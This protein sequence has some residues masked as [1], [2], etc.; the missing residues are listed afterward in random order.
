MPCSWHYW[1]ST[2][3]TNNLNVIAIAACTSSCKKSGF[4]FNQNTTHL[5][6]ALWQMAHSSLKKT[7]DWG[8]AWVTVQMPVGIWQFIHERWAIRPYFQGFL[9]VVSCHGTQNSDNHYHVNFIWEQWME[10]VT[11]VLYKF[12]LILG[13][14][15]VG[16]QWLPPTLYTEM[17]QKLQY[18]LA[19]NLDTNCQNGRTRT[20]A[21]CTNLPSTNWYG[22]LMDQ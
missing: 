7:F 10:T 8:M 16:V 3:Q 21:S 4:S 15:C 6:F 22:Q 19:L 9:H 17:L 12:K 11:A 18:T 14:Y 5:L 1:K 2:V 13:A 20:C